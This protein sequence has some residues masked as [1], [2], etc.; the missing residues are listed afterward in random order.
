[1]SPSTSTSRYT[2]AQRREAA[3]WFV[4]IHADEEPGIDS[5]QAWLHWLDQ[6]EGN[7]A[8]FEAVARTWHSMPVASA[9]PMPSAEELRAD[10]YTGDQPVQEWLAAQ[11]LPGDLPPRRAASRSVRR[12]Q[13]RRWSLLAAASVVAVVVGLFAMN[14]LQIQRGLQANDFTTRAAEQ[15][16][17]TL[18]DGSH[19][20]LGPKST[21]R[22]AFNKE[23]RT[24]QLATGEAFF[25]VKKD[26]GRPFS[27]R[28]NSGD[29]TAV[30]TAF[31][32]RALVDHVTVAVSEG[33]V[34]VAP[35]SQPTAPRPVAVRV[36]SGQ[37][38]TFT[39]QEPIKALA[40]V[41][42]KLLGRV[43]YHKSTPQRLS[44]R[45]DNRQGV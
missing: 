20:W 17:I 23:H 41:I 26:R 38:L 39:A 3:D 43:E 9:L 10:A 13:S 32:V 24:I 2:D 14:R 19:V 21:L 15:I 36:A 6:D 33:V 12:E 35:A 8:A 29:I 11:S 22:V 30:G 34:S 18:A 5:I 45:N 25:S 31:N 4:V 40:V 27:V 28:S 37:Q 16:E 44:V 42:A 7:R 1:M